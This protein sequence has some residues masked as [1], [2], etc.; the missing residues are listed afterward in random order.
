MTLRIKCAHRSKIET[1]FDNTNLPPINASYLQWY[2]QRSIIGRE[3]RIVWFAQK[4]VWL[5]HK[6]ERVH[7]SV[8]FIILRNQVAGCP[9]DHP[10][11]HLIPTPN[12]NTPSLYTILIP[13]CHIRKGASVAGVMDVAFI[14]VIC[15]HTFRVPFS[16]F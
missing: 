11:S 7:I 14:R 13:G 8:M 16:L 15:R 6:T 2:L 3:H 1:E 4:R 5:P 10:A 9:S 12:P